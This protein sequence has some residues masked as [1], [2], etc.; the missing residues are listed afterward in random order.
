MTSN[1]TDGEGADNAG[2]ADGQPPRSL[3]VIGPVTPTNPRALAAGGIVAAALLRG[4]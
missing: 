2:N 1:P 3:P 4:A